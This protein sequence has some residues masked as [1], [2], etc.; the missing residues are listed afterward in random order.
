MI[1][2]L[3]PSIQSNRFIALMQNTT[4]ENYTSVI[5]TEDLFVRKNIYILTL[6]RTSL[7]ISPRTSVI[8]TNP[9]HISGLAS[10][11]GEGIG[12]SIVSET[13]DLGTSKFVFSG[14]YL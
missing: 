10:R 12:A 5:G 8:G 6:F 9:L 13:L 4:E 2:L 3:V 1:Y 7:Q 14:V 11:G